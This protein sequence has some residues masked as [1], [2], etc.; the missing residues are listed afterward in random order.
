M[1]TLANG[2]RVLARCGTRRSWATMRWRGPSSARRTPSRP[3]GARTWWR[4][5]VHGSLTV[6][7]TATP[8]KVPA[9]TQE[10][11]RLLA[12][13]ARAITDTDLEQARNQLAVSLA[14]CRIRRPPSGWATAKNARALQAQLRLR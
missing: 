14:W 6:D 12:A 5:D 8:D 13:Q 9:F 1:H 11:A 3:P 4:G 10:L 2:V 7:A